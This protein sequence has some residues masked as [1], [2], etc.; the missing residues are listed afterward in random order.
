MCPV[1]PVRL[2][3]PTSL[4]RRFRELAAEM[5]P[6]EADPF[7]LALRCA[8][9]EAMFAHADFGPV[10]EPPASLVPTLTV[11]SAVPPEA[12]AFVS[13]LAAR[14]GLT[15]E[16]TWH[17]LV[18]EFCERDASPGLSLAFASERAA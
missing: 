14:S 17:R 16:Q 6:D 7:H 1:T 3:V 2:C 18:L 8:A 15:L 9:A 4:L 10:E 12:A 5:L 11:H 13:T